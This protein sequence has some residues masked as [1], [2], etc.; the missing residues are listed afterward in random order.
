VYV[1]VDLCACLDPDL[2]NASGIRLNQ[3]SAEWKKSGQVALLLFIGFMFLIN[4]KKD[5]ENASIFNESSHVSYKTHYRINSSR[6]KM[7]TIDYR[8]SLH[9]TV[10]CIVP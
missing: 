8:F 4:S 9:V 3:I 7:F 1:S 6:T 10:I 5:T 2:C